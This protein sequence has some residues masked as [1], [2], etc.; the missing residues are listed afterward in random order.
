MRYYTARLKRKKGIIDLSFV[1]LVIT[2]LVIGLIIMFSASYANA[3]FYKGNSFHYITRQLIF[4]VLGIVAMVLASNLDYHVWKRFAWLIYGISLV[5]LLVVYTQ[6]DVNYAKR[7]IFLGPISIQPSEVAKFALVL[8]FARVI[9]KHR[10]KMNT[11]RYG[12]L[13]FLIIFAV[14][15]VLIVFEPHISATMVLFGIAL[16][17]MFVSG[18]SWKWIG[19]GSGIVA[20]G[21]GSVAMVP[22]LLERF[23]SRVD[24]WL[25][26]YLDPRGDGFQTIQSLNAIGSGGLFGLG[27]GNSRQKYLFLPEPQNDYVFSIGCEE[28]GLF[29]AI[30]II[31]LFVMLAWRGI[32]IAMNSRDVFG[33]MLVLGLTSQ[34]A[35]QA[36][37][38]MAVVT[39]TIPPTG[40]SLPFFSYGGT[41]LMMLLG[42]MGIILNVSRT[43][44]LEK[45]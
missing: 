27:I 20:V 11:F 17:M 38:N 29:G 28:L 10:D 44:A 7:W 36:L 5:M 24:I 41:S 43:A 4:A 40:I 31:S 39:N 19:I 3:Y 1:M 18:I 14:P 23:M 25:N 13:P 9:E 15:A 22:H 12:I 8:V 26:P 30:I 34:V 33:C 45:E 6:P 21:A 16:T 37:L 32:A 35:I 2:L 42:Q